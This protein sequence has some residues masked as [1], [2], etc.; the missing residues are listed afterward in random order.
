MCLGDLADSAR[1]DILT[2][3]AGFSGGLALVAHLRHNFGLV[4]GRRQAPRF[5]YRV[6]KRLFAIDV[7]PALDGLHGREGMMMIGRRDDNSVDLLHLVEHLA[8]IGELLRLGI[9]LEDVARVVLI[10]VA[11]GNNVLALHVAQVI[12]ALAADA[13]AG[14]IKLLIRG[15]CPAQAQHTARHHQESGSGEGGATQELAAGE[16][17]SGGSCFSL[18]TPRF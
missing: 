11:K 16:C 17:G 5:P 12:T 6:R 18:H 7:L 13:N 4:G 1:P 9:L 14:D 2:Q 8:V 10:Y 15:G 3:A